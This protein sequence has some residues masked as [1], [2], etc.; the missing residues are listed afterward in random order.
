MS[1][2]HPTAIIEQGAIIN[3]SAIVEAHCFVSSK[4]VLESGVHL[5]QGAQVRNR[6][7][8]GENV[9]IFPYAMIGSIPQDLKYNEQED[10]ALE[11]GANTVIREFATINTG[12]K[13]GGGITKI[14]QNVFI[15]NYCHVA[16]DCI[17]GDNIILAN[18]ATLAGHV[19]V[20]SN[21]VIGG[22]TPVHQFVKIGEGCMI[23]GGSA[24]S[25]DIPPFCLA[26]GNR[27]VV[28]SLNIVGL[29]RSKSK[30]Q[31]DKLKKAYNLLFRS[32]QPLKETAQSIYEQSDDED[33][34]KMCEFILNTKRGI[35]YQ[36]GKHE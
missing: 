19:E 23:A 1:N 11:I 26:E 8:L 31:I 15:M 35:P 33:V 32:N 29:R 21:T 18:N 27:A 20:G 34:K 4:A 13:G 2:I 5:M 36:R 3:E 30:E 25:Q 10:T 24:L 16:H 22:L 14:G 7:T 12:T 9:K 28:K 17:L 6:T